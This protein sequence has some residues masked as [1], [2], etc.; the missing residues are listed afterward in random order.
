MISLKNITLIKL[1]GSLITHKK[2]I[3]RINEYIQEISHFYE[4]NGS[5]SLKGLSEK[6]S[7]LIDHDKLKEIFSIISV[8]LK[9]N[10]QKKIIL[11]HGAG[12]I[13]HSLVLHLLKKHG[14]LEDKF[15][16]VKLAVSIQNQIIVASAIKNGIKAF[17][18]SSHQLMMGVPTD[19]ISS[20][21]GII[22]DLTVLETIITET[23]SVPV[24]YGDVGFT[25]SGWKVFSGDIIPKAL[26]RRFKAIRIENA[27]F[28]TKIEGKRTGIYTKDPRIDDAV[29]IDII[30]VSENDY[31]CFD[32]EGKPLEF[33]IGGR[34]ED[35]DVTEAMGG[36]VRNLIEMAKGYTKSWVVGI[37]EFSNALNQEEVGTRILP[38]S[39]SPAK[40]LFLGTG[41]A[42]GSNGYKSAGIFI[43]LNK[44]GI[45][46]DCGPHTVQSLKKLGKKT[47]DVDIILISHFHGDHI[48]GVPFFLLESSIQQRRTKS[49][50]IVGPK[51]IQ[52]RIKALY[53]SLYEI[54]GKEPVPFPCHY[55]EITSGESNNIEDI[56]IRAITVYHKP[57]SQGYR[58]ESD[59][60]SIA[61][62]GDTGWTENLIPLIKDTDLAIIECNF[63]SEEIDIH[64]NFRQS[65]E[66]IPYTKRLVL[67]H[68]GSEVPE[69]IL[70]NKPNPKIY[71]PLE[72]EELLI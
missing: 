39:R 60:I 55:Q 23:D 62:S 3:Y 28:L 67:T 20:K 44:K 63:Y 57:E 14:D 31:S 36:K 49:L 59:E 58:L 29:L 35:L 13:G 33:D 4:G 8:F 47:D 15:P 69:K 53:E 38:K 6:I 50:T 18:V 45:L 1:G 10:P 11:I 65:L 27:I 68:F 66:L 52:N 19:E 12:S 54:I 34:S 22:E 21:V 30:K 7:E 64:L 51:S 25:K 5:R 37:N 70:Q 2:D 43:E 41:D 32:F 24:F 71:I 40:A 48:G 9:L 26:M 16:L 17:S 46:L 42:F 56:T 61:Y 72:G